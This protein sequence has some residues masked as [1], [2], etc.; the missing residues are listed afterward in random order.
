[1]SVV[2][3]DSGGGNSSSNAPQVLLTE[4]KLVPPRPSPPVC[5]TS[6]ESGEPSGFNDNSPDDSGDNP[7]AILADCGEPAALFSAPLLAWWRFILIWKDHQ[8]D[9]RVGRWGLSRVRAQS[10]SQT[11]WGREMKGC[12]CHS[13]VVEDLSNCWT[14]VQNRCWRIKKIIMANAHERML[15]TGTSIFLD[16]RCGS[17]VCV[18]SA[19]GEFLQPDKPPQ[20]RPETPEKTFKENLNDDLIWRH[21]EHLLLGS[22]FSAVVK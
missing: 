22:T 6:G 10:Y 2:W 7:P 20:L 14:K 18:A 1:M 4:P 11:V 12:D 8:L 17:N 3:L 9:N 16:C 5:S 19:Q 21:M 13:R 15:T